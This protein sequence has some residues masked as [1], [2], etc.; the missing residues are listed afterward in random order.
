METVLGSQTVHALEAMPATDQSM[1]GGFVRNGRWVPKHACRAPGGGAARSPSIAPPLPP[2]TSRMLRAYNASLDH[3]VEAGS[4]ARYRVQPVHRWIDECRERAE[5]VHS[6]PLLPMSQHARCD[7]RGGR[8]A[9]HGVRLLLGVMTA[10]S[11]TVRREAIRASWARWPGRSTL[12]CFVIGLRGLPPSARAALDAEA[13]AHADLVM[14]P[15]VEDQCHVS[16]AKAH[17]W[18]GWAAESGVAHVGRADDDS[19]L[20]LPNLEAD[21]AA[22]AC[23]RHLA[24]GVLASVGYNPEAFRKCGFSWRGDYNWRR[25]GCGATGAH[26]PTP[27]PSGALQILSHPLAATI[28]GA[29][30]VHAFVSRATS[31]IDLLAWDKTEDVALGFMLVQLLASHHPALT[32]LACMPPPHSRHAPHR[33]LRL[34]PLACMAE[35]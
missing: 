16:I 33:P 30:D 3:A 32:S 11:N 2:S 1:S 31:T 27:F 35:S 7:L 24:Y 34:G 18:W 9:E 21:L 13:A 26:E 10:P 22:L 6:P 25:Y 17:G 14:L 29:A 12:V 28:V 4:R 5:G 20:H 8:L 15:D 23:H 19:F